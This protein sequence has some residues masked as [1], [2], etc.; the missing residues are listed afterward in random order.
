MRILGNQTK[1]NRIQIFDKVASLLQLLAVERLLLQDK[2]SMP[3]TPTPLSESP[4]VSRLL[5]WS[6]RCLSSVRT[7]LLRHTEQGYQSL[8]PQKGGGGNKTGLGGKIFRERSELK[9]TRKPSQNLKNRDFKSR[10]GRG[11]LERS[12]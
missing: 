2:D 3:P 1:T 5:R 12:L 4:T 8:S 10:L 7:R 11:G 6:D 9:N